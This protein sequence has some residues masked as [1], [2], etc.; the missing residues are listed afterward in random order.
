[1]EDGRFRRDLFF[2]LN[3]IPLRLPAL[4]ER[5]EDVLLLARFFVDMYLRGYALPATELSGEAVK[6][7]QAYAWPGNVRELQNLMERAVLLCGGKSIRPGHFLLENEEWPLFSESAADA[8]EAETGPPAPATSAGAP[9]TDDAAGAG[10]E[11]EDFVPP[12]GDAQV[13][14]SGGV[15]PLS[16]ME[17][18][19]I[20]KGLEQTGGNRTQAAELLGIS[21][22]TLRNKLNEYRQAGTDAGL[23]E[24]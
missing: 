18:I 14:F 20:R 3:V 12:R 8:G 17:R 19:M 7:L 15:I 9:D 23:P 22:R 4:R 5:G 16:E 24:R 13:D 11:E 21:V 10:A 1:V 2:R 6:W